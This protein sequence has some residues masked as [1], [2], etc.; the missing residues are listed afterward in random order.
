MGHDELV[1]AVVVAVVAAEFLQE[2]FAYFVV[3]GVAEI[4]MSV[5]GYGQC[6]MV[7]LADVISIHLTHAHHPLL[8]QQ[9]HSKTAGR[10]RGQPAGLEYGGVAGFDIF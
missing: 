9:P 6:I 8:T 7:D 10:V 3:E 5:D 2:V 4:G 1:I